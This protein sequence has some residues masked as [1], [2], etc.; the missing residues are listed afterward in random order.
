MNGQCS[1]RILCE[2]QELLC[3][4]LTD[5]IRSYPYYQGDWFAAVPNQTFDLIIS[6]PPYIAE[7]DAHLADLKHEPIE[8][9]SSGKDGLEDIKII[10]KQAPLHLN[11][12]GFLLLEH[13]YD[14]RKA[15]IEMLKA[16]FTSIKTFTDYNHQNRAILA[17]LK[18]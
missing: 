7:N 8:A 16:T 2:T 1:C 17:Q 5:S 14:Q 18:T 10:I 11:K 12:Q 4:K 13:G 9:L 3:N 15:I 6:N